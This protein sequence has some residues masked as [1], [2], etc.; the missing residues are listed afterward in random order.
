MRNQFRIGLGS[1]GG[2]AGV[3]KFYPVH[4]DVTV[5]Q[6]FNLTVL[7]YTLNAGSTVK[8]KERNINLRLWSLEY[9]YIYLLFD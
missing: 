2:G 9:D 5:I 7:F 4:D 1:T 8:G 6:P 3:R